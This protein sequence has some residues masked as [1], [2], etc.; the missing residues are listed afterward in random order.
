MQATCILSNARNYQALRSGIFSSFRDNLPVE[1]QL[2]IAPRAVQYSDSNC[3]DHCSDES[4]FMS[5]TR[6]V[7]WKWC[8]GLLP[9]SFPSRRIDRSVELFGSPLIYLSWQY[10][11]VDPQQTRDDGIVQHHLRFLGPTLQVPAEFQTGI[12]FRDSR[13]PRTLPD[14]TSQW[15]RTRRFLENKGETQ[16]QSARHPKGARRNRVSHCGFNSGRMLGGCSTAVMC[17]G[18]LR[19]V[20]PF[21]D[22]NERL[23]SVRDELHIFVAIL[24]LEILCPTPK[25]SGLSARGTRGVQTSAR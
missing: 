24:A 20:E 23:D 9:C 10:G 12:Y 19:A 7:S 2:Q 4:L 25:Y 13:R 22:V 14:L 3:S 5:G 1:D 17:S 8:S 11:Y 16:T 18:Y 15:N 6:Q 21:S